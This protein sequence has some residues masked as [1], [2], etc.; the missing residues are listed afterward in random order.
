MSL[1]FQIIVSAFLC[2]ILFCTCLDGKEQGVPADKGRR[3]C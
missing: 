1:V 2:L 3:G